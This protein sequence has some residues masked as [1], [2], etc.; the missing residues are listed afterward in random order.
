MSAPA[1]LEA[2][3]CSRD[4]RCQHGEYL[5]FGR[6]DSMGGNALKNCKTR[7]YQAAEFASL[8]NEVLTR[9][10]ADF[11]GRRVALLPAYRTKADFGD[12]DILVE[13]APTGDLLRWAVETW[14]PQ[15]VVSN[16][17]VISFE[18]RDLQVDLIGQTP[19]NFDTALSYFAWNDLGNFLGRIA[20]KM[21]VKY[22]HE[23]L[24]VVFREGDYQFAERVVSKD[25]DRILRYFGYDPDRWHAGFDTL[26]E[27]YAFAA[28]TPYFNPSI[29]A[30]ESRNHAARVRDRKRVVY[31]GFLEWMERQSDLPAYLWPSTNELGGRRLDGPAL[32]RLLEAFPE[33][34]PQYQV[35]MADF[36]VWRQAKDL[37]N[38][39]IV[40][41]ITQLTDRELGEFMRTLTD[42]RGPEFN[43]RIVA[44]GKIGVSEWV[45]SEFSRWPRSNSVGP[46]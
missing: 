11:P 17:N 20:H 38:G 7:R 21:G 2:G 15:E 12:M 5:S 4:K 14:S 39:K 31:R 25:T 32:A 3:A 26:E 9:L 6:A 13:T 28:S 22:G 29:F 10:Q 24:S 33:F 1:F 36:A 34:A 27:I 30:Y 16:G 46:E 41:E 43:S 40:G 37:F 19:E 44:L 35:V 23:G 45:L 8:A 18:C 42:E